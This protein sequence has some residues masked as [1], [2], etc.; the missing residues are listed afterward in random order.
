M[1]Y[2]WQSKNRAQATARIR[3]TRVKSSRLV[4]PGLEKF[5]LGFFSSL[6]VPRSRDMTKYTCIPVPEN[7]RI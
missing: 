3:G 5:G 4:G 2:P 6:D 1:R 7:M